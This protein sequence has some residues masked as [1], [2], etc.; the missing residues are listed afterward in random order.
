MICCSLGREID[1]LI[2]DARFD[3]NNDSI[4]T[5]D[6]MREPEDEDDFRQHG[7]LPTKP[8]P[9]PIVSG[10]HKDEL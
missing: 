9:T 1:C 2:Y 10:D 4:I 6:E 5:L 7:A 3:R 8:I